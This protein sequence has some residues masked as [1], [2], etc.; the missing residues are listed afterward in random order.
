MEKHRIY[1]YPLW[2][3]IWHGINALSII[4]LIVSGISMQ[5]SDLQNPLMSFGAAVALHNIAGVVASIGYAVFFIN[6]IVSG[7][8]KHYILRF[9]GLFQRLMLQAKYYMFG[10]FKNETKPFPITEERKFNPLQKIAYFSAMYFIVPVLVITGI[11]LLYPEMIVDRVFNIGGI[12]FTALLHAAVGFFAS[13]FLLIHLYVVSVGKHPFR[14]FKSIVT[15]Y[16]E[17]D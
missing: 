17:S 9:K 15:G 13:I 16:H 3:R 5:Y 2:I 10:Y 11:A 6:N 14:N 8:Y 7:N 1:L 12:Q 4:T